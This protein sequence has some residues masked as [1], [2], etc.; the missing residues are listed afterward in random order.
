MMINALQARNMTFICGMVG[1]MVGSPA[2]G[3]GA[4]RGESPNRMYSSVYEAVRSSRQS[5]PIGMTQTLSMSQSPTLAVS[6][7]ISSLS[8]TLPAAVPGGRAA[9]L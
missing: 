1:G 3:H 7:C 6:T 8:L 9:D 5:R 4:A 2:W